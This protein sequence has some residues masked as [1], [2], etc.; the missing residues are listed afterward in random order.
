[1]SM[2]RAIL[3]VCVCVCVNALGNDFMDVKLAVYDVMDRW[4]GVAHA[5]GLSPSQV[6]TIQAQHPGNIE[7]C[8]DESLY[9]WLRRAHNEEKFGPPTWKKLVEA[10]A[11]R[12]GGQNRAVSLEIAKEHTS[13]CG[14]GIPMGQ[15]KVSSFS[16]ISV[17]QML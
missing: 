8:L 11:A 7:G 10:V 9:V 15:K 6:R 16:E 4:Q 5:I 13:E 3:S 2:S 14:I 17:V 12:A 1:M